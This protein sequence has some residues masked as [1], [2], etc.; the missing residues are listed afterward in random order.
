MVQGWVMWEDGDKALRLLML[1]FKS[2]AEIKNVSK[3]YGIF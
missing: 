3:C 2:R 1:L